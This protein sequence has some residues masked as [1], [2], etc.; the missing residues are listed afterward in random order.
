[1]G[2]MGMKKKATRWRPEKGEYFWYVES[3]GYVQECMLYGYSWQKDLVR[4][5]NCFRTRREAL[6]AKPRVRKALRGD[7]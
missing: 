7:V 2:E 5:D 1:M 6:K 3:D 4:F